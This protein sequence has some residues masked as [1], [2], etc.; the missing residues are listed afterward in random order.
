MLTP[1]GEQAARQMGAELF[2][3]HPP[4]HLYHSTIARCG[5]TAHCLLQ[6]M[7]PVAG[8]VVNHGP[9]PMLAAC[10][11]PDSR[12]TYQYCQ[13]QGMDTLQFIQQWFAGS[14]LAELAMP[15]LQAARNQ[16]EFMQEQHQQLGG[17]QLHVSH[18]WNMMLFIVFYLG[19]T[20]SW[21]AWPGFLEGVL[22]TWESP[23]VRL[24][25]RHHTARLAL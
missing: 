13:N 17:F 12:Y 3:K 19:L 9:H 6:G 10:Y 8:Q 22:L 21:A 14:L 24:Q 18:D 7:G 11:L 2:A 5:Q 4:A 16:L 25:F 15:A 23:G 20:P 1:E